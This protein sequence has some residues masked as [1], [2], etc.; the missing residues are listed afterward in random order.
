MSN[1]KVKTERIL[2][3]AQTIDDVYNTLLAQ[4]GEVENMIASVAAS[5]SSNTFELSKNAFNAI[6]DN[7]YEKRR[8]VLSNNSQYLISVVVDGYFNT[9]EKNRRELDDLISG[10][11]N[12]GQVGNTIKN[13]Y[14]NWDSKV[15]QRLGNFES[16]AYTTENM[17]HMAYEDRRLDGQC[18]WYAYGRFKEIT[19]IKLSSALHAK[20]WLSQNAGDSQVDVWGA[21]PIKYPSIGVSTIDGDYGHVFIVEHVEMDEK[22][23]PAYVY[24]SEANAADDDV[25]DRISNKD[26]IIQK[27]PYD[28]YLR[29]KRPSGYITAK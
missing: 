29:T 26:G 3:L 11:P 8:D 12:G 15:G 7:F 28:E 6:K 17:S 14:R 13:D 2:T 19:G 4:F 23:E 20:F 21:E 25:K 22:G 16:T 1:I 18:T 27:L 10:M 5:W 9:E 24:V